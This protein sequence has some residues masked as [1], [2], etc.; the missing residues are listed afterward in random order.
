MVFNVKLSPAPLQVLF[1]SSQQQAASQLL[2]HHIMFHIQLKNW[3]EIRCDVLCAVYPPLSM[4]DWAVKLPYA[5]LIQHDIA[6]VVFPVHCIRQLSCFTSLWPCSQLLA[7]VMHSANFSFHCIH[8]IT[9]HSL[10]KMFT[11]CLPS[12]HSAQILSLVHVQ[13]FLNSLF[14]SGGDDE[15]ERQ[16]CPG[17][18]LSV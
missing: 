14:F 2:Y 3:T 17:V 5:L 11:T 15:E 18:L 8:L 13:L 6:V 7:T 1:F 12:V 16:R 10:S 9:T 4:Q